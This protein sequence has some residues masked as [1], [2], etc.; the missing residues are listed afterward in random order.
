[1]SNN[2]SWLKVTS[3]TN[4]IRLF[5]LNANLDFLRYS[6]V[7]YTWTD[8]QSK[9]VKLPAPQ[10]IDYMATSIENLLNDETLFP[11]KAGM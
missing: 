3:E 1:M 8:N 7:E 5:N 10:Y 2:V 9:K 4:R 11:T 6:S